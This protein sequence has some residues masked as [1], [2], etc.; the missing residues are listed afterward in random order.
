MG[1]MEGVGISGKG[2]G[3]RKKERRGGR[4]GKKSKNTPSVNSCPRPWATGICSLVA[5]PH[6]HIRIFPITSADN[7]SNISPH[8]TTSKIRTS[9]NLHFTGAPNFTPTPTSTSNCI[10]R[11][12]G[13]SEMSR[14]TGLRMYTFVICMP[15]ILLSVIIQRT[16]TSRLLPI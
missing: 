16:S 15:N 4:G 7:I 14:S 12:N 2:E 3:E 6:C 13:E 8:F 1:G 11:P 10:P 5:Y 9:A